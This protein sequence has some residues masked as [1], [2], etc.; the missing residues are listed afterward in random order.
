VG[1]LSVSNNG[2]GGNFFHKLEIA[3]SH[4]LKI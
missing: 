1:N 2:L 3:Q 4:M